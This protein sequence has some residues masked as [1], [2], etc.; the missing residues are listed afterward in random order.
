MIWNKKKFAEYEVLLRVI[1]CKNSMVK[2]LMYSISAEKD[3]IVKKDVKTEN[4]I[5]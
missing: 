3:L 2:S 1:S 4:G 5:N